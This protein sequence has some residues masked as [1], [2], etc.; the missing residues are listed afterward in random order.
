VIVV[1]TNTIAYLLIPGSMTPAA[2]SA[3][4]KDPD[5][6]APIL[7]R[8]EFRNVLS[9]L[10]RRAELA[11]EDATVLMEQA[12]RLMRNGEH[13]VSSP[14]VLEISFRS[15][16]SAYDCEFVALALELGVPLITSDRKI[17]RAF[18]RTARALR[19]FAA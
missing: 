11:L 1:D 7:W 9:L 6:R 10:I 8:S 17:L 18:P 14:A 13:R 19:D 3:L 5:W 12:E 16:C 15:G 4:L 2:K